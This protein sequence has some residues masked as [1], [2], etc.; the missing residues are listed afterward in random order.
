MNN[1][2]KLENS[3]VI[4]DGQTVTLSESIIAPEGQ[5]AVALPG[6]EAQ[7]IVTETGS[8]AAPDEGNTAVQSLGNDVNIVNSGSLFGDFNGIDSDG[9]GFNLTNQGTI[10]SNSR[11][12]QLDDGDGLN[13]LNTG[14][15]NGTGNQRNGTVYIDGTV[16]NAT[17]NNQGLINAGDGNSGDGLS[18]Q[19]GATSEDAIDENI[20]IVNSGAILGRGQAEFAPGE[21]RL[22]A[23]GSSGVR[24]FNGSDEPEATVTGSIT[25][26]GLISAEVNVGFLGGVVV[27]DGVAFAGTINNDGLITAPRN[28]LYIGNAQH[29]LTINNSGT[30]QSGSRA[31]NLDGDN[32]TVNNTGTIFGIGDQRNGTTYID[33]TGDN[34]TLNNLVVIDPGEGNVGD[35][36][37]IQA[38]ATSEDAVNENINIVNSGAILGRGQAEFAPGEGRLTA[39]GSSGVRFFNGSGEPEATVTGSITNTGL[40]SAEVN[41][42]FLGGVVVEDGVAFAGT[43]DNDG[44]ITAPRNGLYIGNAQHD[45][46]INNSGRIESGSRAVNLDGDNVTLN[47]DGG[48]IGTDNQRNGTVYIDGTGD[49]I[50]INNSGLIDAGD[51]NSGSGVSVQVGTV[52][53]LGEGIDDVETSANITNNGLIQ[54]RGT[55][56]VPAGVRLF[57]GS[58]LTEST[59]TGDIT[60]NGTITSEQQAGI[61]IEEGIIFNGQITN[62]GTISGGNGLALDATGANGPVNVE[63]NATLDGTVRLGEGDDNFVQ[64]SSENVEVTGGLGNDNITGGDGSDTVRFD[65][66]DVSVTV[67]LG[68]GTAQR[69]TGFET[70]ITDLALVNPNDGINSAEIVSEGVAG[71]LYF[72]F[73]TADFPAGELR[74]QLELFADNRDANGV[75]TV[76]FT[77]SLSGDQ[78]VQDEPVITDAFG[79]ATA[80]FTVSEDGSISYSAAASLSGLNQ[81]DLFPVNIGNGTLSP[82]HLHNAPAGANGPVVV[83]IFTDAGAD[84][85]VAISET[86]SLVDIENVVGSFDADNIIGNGNS[87]LLEGLDGGD[88]LLGGDGGDT[89]I[90]GDGDDFLQGGGGNDLIEGGEGFDTVSFADIGAD[91]TVSLNDD[92]TGSAEYIINGNT[93]IDT[94]SGIEAVVGSANNDNITFTPDDPI[95]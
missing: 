15:I 48:V 78:E 52:D 70:T 12:V 34:I 66:I 53:G 88:T 62:N 50:T 37:S 85:I 57:V 7:L 47:N 64:N 45:L 10:S 65:D 42:G 29:D 3:L 84:G 14:V 5:P 77:A 51:S 76:V 38:G 21:G 2:E 40:I 22:T 18:A 81:A 91:V 44:L 27:E 20:T 73:H 67:D 31:L 92:G 6:N 56:N 30:I 25:N 1:T 90:G 35:G 59:F 55:E 11:A 26:T 95:I 69:E 60:N 23:N 54:G 19:I 58:G 39:N 82:I 36:F 24:F 8:I 93:V 79:T 43:I 87:N 13:L 49:N 83:D 32:V 46:T 33:G 63:N 75:G 28:G 80:T 9:D 16:D 94:F 61:L 71:N 41:V 4:E 86:D 89:L 17:V 72:N 74:G 68:A